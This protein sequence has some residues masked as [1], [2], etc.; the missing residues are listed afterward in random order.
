MKGYSFT[1]GFFKQRYLKTLLIGKVIILSVMDKW[2]IMQ[3]L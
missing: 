3:T 2:V 1:V